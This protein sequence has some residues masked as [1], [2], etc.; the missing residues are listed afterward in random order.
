MEK[1][2][3][4]LSRIVII[5]LIVVLVVVI[6]IENNTM[7]QEWSGEVVVDFAGNANEAP[8]TA[9]DAMTMQRRPFFAHRGAL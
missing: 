8:T 1:I 5:I 4:I 7:T 3:A 9:S 6:S 2:A